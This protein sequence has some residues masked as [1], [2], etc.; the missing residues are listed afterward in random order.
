MA[1]EEAVSTRWKIPRKVCPVAGCVEPVR[2]DRVM[3]SPHWRSVSS[4]LRRAHHRIY[5]TWTADR[6]DI[7]ALIALRASML[8]C[9]ADANT[10]RALETA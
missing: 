6:R 9:V 7:A 3:C 2:V 4:D 5:R 8:A 10:A 1:A